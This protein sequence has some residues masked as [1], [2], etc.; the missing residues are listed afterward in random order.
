[1]IRSRASGK[2]RLPES[3]PPCGCSVLVFAFASS[4]PAEVSDKDVHD[5]YDFTGPVLGSGA[6]ATVLLVKDRM[7]GV[8][9]AMKQVSVLPVA[10]TVVVSDGSDCVTP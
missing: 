8:E 7:S 10:G 5:V 9:Y 1:M 4:P 6:F 3:V 2:R